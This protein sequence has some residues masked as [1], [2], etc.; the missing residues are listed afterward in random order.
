MAA[1]NGTRVSLFHHI[2]KS[3]PGIFRKKNNETTL[4]PKK[5]LG[6]L[7]SL[8]VDIRAV[9]TYN[10]QP[11]QMDYFRITNESSLAE[12]ISKQIS[13]VLLMFCESNWESKNR[14]VFLVHDLCYRAGFIRMWYFVVRLTSYQD[15]LINYSISDNSFIFL[16]SFKFYLWWRHDAI[17]FDA[18]TCE[19]VSSF[20][21][22]TNLEFVE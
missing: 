5:K 7:P 21:V 10:R 6:H 15:D 8:Y 17:T 2:T 20:F 1:S 13:S 12:Q 14:L 9:T 11:D 18:L 3:D 4:S 16:S 22:L 19:D